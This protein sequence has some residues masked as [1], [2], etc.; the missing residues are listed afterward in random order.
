[1]NNPLSYVKR[2]IVDYNSL[3]D[4]KEDMDGD[5]VDAATTRY[6]EKEKR[7]ESLTDKKFRSTKVKHFIYPEHYP[8]VNDALLKLIPILDNSR[9][10]DN[11]YV[12]E[13]NYLIYKKGDHFTKHRDQIMREPP[14]DWSQMRVYSTSTMISESED[15]EGGEFIFYDKGDGEGEELKIEKGETLIFDSTKAHEVKPVTKGTREVLVAWI[16]YKKI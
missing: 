10:S 12:F 14:I 13:Y 11:F 2:K 7:R 4:M 16:A 15:F 9:I 1:M 3:L 8:D 5:L 6:N